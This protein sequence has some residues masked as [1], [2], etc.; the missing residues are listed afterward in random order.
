MNGR[1]PYKRFRPAEIVS[2]PS[3]KRRFSENGAK[4]LY[5][6]RLPTG[7]RTVRLLLPDLLPQRRGNQRHPVFPASSGR[8]PGT[9]T[10]QSGPDSTATDQSAAEPTEPT[11]PAPTERAARSGKRSRACPLQPRIMR[12]RV[13]SPPGH[14]RSL[15]LRYLHKLRSRKPTFFA[16]G[17]IAGS[18]AQNE[19]LLATRADRHARQ[20]VAWHCR[21]CLRRAKHDEGNGTAR[22]RDVGLR[23]EDD[24][25]PRCPARLPEA[26]SA[27][28][29]SQ[30]FAAAP[31]N[32]DN[33]QWIPP[34]HNARGARWYG[35]PAPLTMRD[36][37]LRRSS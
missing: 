14:G 16:S 18:T 37:N 5:R 34:L 32:G 17:S 11:E 3:L 24:G 22:A 21:C 30:H 19:Q 10:P 33:G 6:R 23:A 25:S 31:T 1:A 28:G 2:E 7:P 4:P 29:V 20:N 15:P 12:P 13:P 35:E 36:R 26:G 8:R 9:E 27:L